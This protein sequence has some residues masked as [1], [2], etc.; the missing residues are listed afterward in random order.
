MPR[1]S[2]KFIRNEH[3]TVLNDDARRI[4]RRTAVATPTQLHE[5]LDGQSVQILELY[6]PS[7][8][9]SKGYDGCIFVIY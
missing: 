1:E 2:G 5:V 3:V 6:T 4:P 9:N 7:V 8:S